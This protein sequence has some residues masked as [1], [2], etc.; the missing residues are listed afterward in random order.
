VL[1]G[2]LHRIFTA[3][4]RVCLRHG[5]PYD[6]VAELAKRAFVDVAYREFT[7]PGRK[8]SASRVALLTGV[9][10][11]DIARMLAAASP[12]DPATSARVAHS[13]R[14]IAGWRRD[15]AFLDRRGKPIVLAFD[16]GSPS[17]VDLVRT[18]G[19][20]DVPPRAVLDELVRVG[21]V[22]RDKRGNIRL[23]AAAYV[24]TATS[25]ERLVIFGT[26]VADL[27]AVLDHNLAREP[28]AGFFQR[29]VAYDNLP[30]EALDDIHA[31]VRREGQ[32]VLEKLDKV[33]AKHDRDANPKV[34]GTGRKRAMVGIY[35]FA[36][37]ADESSESEE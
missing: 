37:D 34:R 29:K 17:F 20:G 13:A 12:G 25:A 36:D 7:V 35:Y 28:E 5:M 30:A 10:R 15:P 8:Q 32:A 18:Y 23:D 3:V 2:A 27:I 21:A 16:Q 24:P 19:G 22:R 9:H 6:A 26:D 11:K 33:M 4:A 31:R 14:V 1:E